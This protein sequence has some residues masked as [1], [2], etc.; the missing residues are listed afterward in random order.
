MERFKNCFDDGIEVRLHVNIPEAQNTITSRSQE[1]VSPGVISTAFN[2]LTPIQFDDDPAVQRRE[3]ANIE[4][5]LML[6]SKL[7]AAKLATSQTAPE[8]AFRRSL[9]FSESAHMLKHARIRS[10]DLGVTM[11]Y[12]ATYESGHDPSAPVRRGHLPI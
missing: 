8:K 5:D 11:S 12:I 2:M 9:V 4:P 10:S 7:E 1:T 6:P 3:V